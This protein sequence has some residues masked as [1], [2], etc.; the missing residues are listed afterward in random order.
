M[1]E[2]D[3]QFGVIFDEYSKRNVSVRN[4]EFESIAAVNVAPVSS[5][6]TKQDSNYKNGKNWQHSQTAKSLR[7]TNNNSMYAVIAALILLIIVCCS[8]GNVGHIFGIDGGLNQSNMSTNPP[9]AAFNPYARMNDTINQ[10]N[11]WQM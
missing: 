11:Q 7:A 4:K 2:C 10:S 3:R 5:N 9:P 1:G 6:P 8:W